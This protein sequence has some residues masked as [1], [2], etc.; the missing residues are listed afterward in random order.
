MLYHN[1][2]HKMNH[3]VFV[4]VSSTYDQSPEEAFQ[5]KVLKVLVYIKHFKLSNCMKSALEIVCLID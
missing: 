5:T 1:A 2:T 4:L 3:K